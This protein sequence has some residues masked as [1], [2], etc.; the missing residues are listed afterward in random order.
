MADPIQAGL[1]EVL[2]V[3]DQAD[4]R[5]LLERELTEA[6]LLV[7]CADSGEAALAA[8]RERRPDAVLLDV[9]MGGMDGFETCRQIREFDE[10]LPVI[11][12]TG[13]DETG[14]I[15]R[16]FE[17]GATDYVAKPVSAPEV[18]ARLMAHTRIS[19]LVRATREAVEVLGVPLMAMAADRLLWLN[20]AAATLLSSCLPGELL[21]EDAPVP[22]ALRVALAAQADA[23]TRQIQ[24]G[25]QRLQVTV[26]SE[27]GAAVSVVSFTLESAEPSSA[28]SAAWTAPHLTS[29]ETEVLLWVARGKTN[30]DIAEILGMSPR[31]VNK[32]LEHVFEKLGVETRTAAA[33]AAQ[34]LRLA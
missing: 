3:D 26:M 28:A 29:R 6:G 5:R 13:L 24:V 17:V 30:R 23:R 19:R 18:V 12:T 16:G 14:H 10:G 11:F 1:L 25:E 32:H 33:A 22:E 34:R 9:I 21:R 8:I 15:V 4:I 27:P 7:R 31:T 20:T 2:V